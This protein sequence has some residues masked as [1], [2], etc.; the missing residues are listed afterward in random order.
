M[1]NQKNQCCS[2]TRTSETGSLSVENYVLSVMVDNQEKELSRLRAE[3]DVYC[4]YATELAAISKELQDRVKVLVLERALKESR[5]GVLQAAG[6]VEK[7]R[8]WT[9][10]LYRLCHLS[11]K[12]QKDVQRSKDLGSTKDVSSCQ[13]KTDKV[14]A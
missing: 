12:L 11:T 8:Y 10:Q 6:S 1:C 7:Q 13:S 2:T 14:A 5:S 4:G 9:A 3:R